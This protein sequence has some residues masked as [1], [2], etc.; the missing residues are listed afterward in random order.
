MVPGHAVPF[1][2]YFRDVLPIGIA[3]FSWFLSLL[4]VVFFSQRCVIRQI[5]DADLVQALKEH[6]LV[7][8]T[9]SDQSRPI[10]QIPSRSL[11]ASGDPLRLPSVALA[12]T[13]EFSRLQAEGGLQSSVGRDASAA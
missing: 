11:S 10:Y 8:V 6:S 1:L 5:D 3:M 2:E 4:R 13:R 12:T 9:S 7:L